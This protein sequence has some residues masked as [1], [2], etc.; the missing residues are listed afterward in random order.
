[1]SARDLQSAPRNPARGARL[2]GALL[3]G[4]LLSGS[5]ARADKSGAL[6]EHE[7][8]KALVQ[9][10]AFGS[11]IAAFERAYREFPSPQYLYNIAQ[12]YRRNL[13]DCPAARG[14]YE[15]FLAASPFQHEALER[16]AVLARKH[17][18]GFQ[19]QCP[20]SDPSR[21]GSSPAG[22]PEP[23][24]ASELA[25]ETAKKSPPSPAPV[26]SD[27]ALSPEVAREKAPMAPLL[28]SSVY[29]TSTTGP[30]PTWASAV[31]VGGGAGGLQYSLGEVEV[32]ATAMLQM[33]VGLRLPPRELYSTLALSVELA[34]MRWA[35]ED[36]ERRGTALF[37]PLLCTFGITSDTEGL[38]LAG[39]VGVGAL[40]MSGLGKGNPFT[41]A[42]TDEGSLLTSVVRLAV[43]SDYHLTSRF[44]LSALVSAQAA[45]PPQAFASDIDTIT[46]VGF[47]L[48]LRHTL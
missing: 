29:E 25:G 34:P 22:D 17:L 11:A 39:S 18:Q 8:A 27:R 45:S 26:P 16:A 47:A 40:L 48:G 24:P 12:I 33:E 31:F 7:R 13:N 43:G 28:E 37:T 32:P 44:K 46:G 20:P 38:A 23:A 1:M 19:E 3:L 14:Y 5:V 41:M 42:A 10:G 30:S 4:A 21:R 35:S 6:R 15:R 9:Q 36:G 2:V